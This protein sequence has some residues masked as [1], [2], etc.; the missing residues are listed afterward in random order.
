MIIFNYGGNNMNEMPGFGNIKSVDP[1][2]SVPSS[3]FSKNNYVMSDQEMVET[4]G[5]GMIDGIL[6]DSEL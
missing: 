6:Y 1:T 5:P 2:V 4:R 3:T